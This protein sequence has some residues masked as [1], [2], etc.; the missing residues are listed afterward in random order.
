M[1]P[2]G[3]VSY[4]PPGVSCGVFAVYAGPPSGDRNFQPVL[5][6]LRKRSASRRRYT[7][8]SGARNLGYEKAC[9]E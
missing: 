2:G 8:L 3:S 1:E 6:S 4:K 5:Y 7:R 9:D